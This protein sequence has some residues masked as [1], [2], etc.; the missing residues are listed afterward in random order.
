MTI[1]INVVIFLAI[2]SYV[3]FTLFN[4]F[5]KAKA[6]KC[7]SCGSKR[8]CHTGKKTLWLS[9]TFDKFI[10][11]YESGSIVKS[12]YNVWFTSKDK[13]GR[14]I[15]LIKTKTSISITMIGIDVYFVA[16]ELSY[17]LRDYVLLY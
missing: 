11:F 5:K 8:G 6:G 4:F 13:I 12:F 16:I 3:V 15:S 17:S 9:I 1:I 7:S 10:Y 14:L 2:I